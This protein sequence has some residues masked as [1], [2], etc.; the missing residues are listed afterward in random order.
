MKIN[1]K[2]LLLALVLMLSLSTCFANVNKKDD[3]ANIKNIGNVIIQIQNM[4][5][6]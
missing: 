5:L 2:I 6:L 4:L 1:N 3:N